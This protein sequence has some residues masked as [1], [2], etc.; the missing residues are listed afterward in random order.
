MAVKWVTGPVTVPERGGL[1]TV[2]AVGS[3]QPQR[4]TVLLLMWV[5]G[6]HSDKGYNLLWHEG[7]LGDY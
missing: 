2:Q 7:E 3:N 5:V 1:V 4:G 6:A